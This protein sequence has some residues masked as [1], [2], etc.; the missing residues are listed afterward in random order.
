MWNA[1]DKDLI[2]LA[3]KEIRQIN[4]ANGADIIDGCVIR[5]PK[6]Y[7]VHDESYQQH[8]DTIRTARPQRHA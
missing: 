2:A 6:A 7:P 1:P 8:V 4:L 5:Q 3:T